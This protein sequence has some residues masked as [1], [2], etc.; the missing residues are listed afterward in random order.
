MP[1]HVGAITKPRLGSAIVLARLVLLLSCVC[2]LPAFSSTPALAADASSA[3]PPGNLLASAVVIDSLDL[4][5]NSRAVADDSILASGAAWGFDRGIRFRTS[6]G[7]ITYD[8]GRELPIAA[9]YLQASAGNLFSL[10]VSSDGKSYREIW[11]VPGLRDSVANGFATYSETFVGERGRYVRIGD[12]TGMDS[13]T[14]TELQLFCEIPAQ[15]PPSTTT[16]AAPPLVRGPWVWALGPRTADR[17]KIAIACAAFLLLLWGRTLRVRGTP[18]RFARLRDGLLIALALAAYTGYYNWGNYHFRERIHWHEFFH[19]YIGSKYFPEVG[20]THLY[21]AACVA[22]VE[23]GFRHRVEERE[24]RDLTR[25]ELVPATYVLQDPERYKQGFARPFTPARWEAFKK[26]IA[27]F[28]DGAGIEA[29]EHMLKDHGYNPSPVWNMGG[30]VLAN[31]GPASDRLIRG[32]LSWIDPALLLIAFALIVWAFGWRVACI[33]AIFFGTNQPALYFWTGGAFLRQDWLLSAI[34]GLCFLKRGHPLW[35]GAGLAISTLLRVFPVGFFVG[36]GLRLVWVLI[37][38]RRVDPMGAKIVAGAAL[39]TVILLPASSFVAGSARAWPVFFENTKKHSET[40]LTNNMGLR[41]VV[42]F[43]WE[44]RQRFSYDPNL[45]DPF[46][47]FKEARR[48]TFQARLPIFLAFLA[49]YLALLFRVSMREKAWWVL[50]VFGF[51]VIPFATEL[52]CYYYSFLLVAAFLWEKRDAIPI[53]LLALAAV[54]QIIAFKTYF[55][56][57]RYMVET[58]AVLAFAAWATWIYG[59]GAGREGAVGSAAP[60]SKA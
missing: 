33:A 59:S 8:L 25:N 39:A 24:I 50:G 58:L 32:F 14:I 18:H 15:W 47:K 51:G 7:S 20:Y 21:E 22:E 44:S 36:I 31:L 53:W 45:A 5:G 54:T 56:D 16:I 13:R 41:T 40:P 12:A 11:R 49:G 27:Y 35:G 23:Q 37:R 10:E 46:H 52:T 29:W 28:R 57:V 3:C 60:V 55:Y 30:S 9:A 48:Q 34:A 2:P 6:A 1:R 43:G 19:Y 38:E 4:A 26:D 17:I 42:S